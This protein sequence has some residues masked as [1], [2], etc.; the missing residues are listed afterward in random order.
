[1][2]DVKVGELSQATAG[3]VRVANSGSISKENFM[4]NI[5]PET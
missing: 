4:R 5:E 1:M 3:I 2:R